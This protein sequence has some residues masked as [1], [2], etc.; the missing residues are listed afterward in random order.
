MKSRRYLAAT[1]ILLLIAA[2]GW[3]A[4]NLHPQREKRAD[5]LV[6][7][8]D[9]ESLTQWQ[10]FSPSK[11]LDKD[12]AD[13]VPLKPSFTPDPAEAIAIPDSLP[14]AAATDD[15]RAFFTYHAVITA[16]STGVA[17][18]AVPHLD[19][20]LTGGSALSDAKAARE[21]FLSQVFDS[22]VM[23]SYL[24]FAMAKVVIQTIQQGNLR[25]G[26]LAWGS[27][28]LGNAALR[29]YDR[30]GE[31][32]YVALYLDYF[33]K[34]MALRDSQLGLADDFHGKVMDA[35]GSA[36]LGR[37]TGDPSI[38]VAHVT[39]FSVL[40]AP[41]TGFAL[42]IRKDP[43]LAAYR[44]QADRIIAYFEQAYPQFDVDRKQPEGT[45]ELWYWRPL[46]NQYEATN[47]L[48]IQG[49][50]LLNMYLATGRPDYADR[51]RA[52]IRIFEKGATIDGQ[53][54]ASWNYNPYFQDGESNSNGR[55]PSEF[56]WKG[57]LTVPFLYQA[58]EAGFAVDPA[59]MA[60]IT[61]NVKDWIV[62]D[63]TFK[64]NV[65]PKDSGPVT[66]REKR[67]DSAGPAASITGFL[68][69][70]AADRDIAERIRVM[71]ATR[72]DIFPEGW[73]LSDKMAR[74][75]A[76]FLTR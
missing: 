61:R 1:A 69:A 55:E 67:V 56:V 14:C 34:L 63:N 51:I 27:G 15:T 21:A 8:P 73:F 4:T 75:Y 7:D 48:H 49:E 60:A 57:G 46:I 25:H 23:Y 2:L 66:E 44:P 50:A 58:V 22:N 71:V 41:A 16:L 32:R 76:Y 47:H 18:A 59:L 20:F 42:R 31:V 72:P 65:N 11:R 28:H 33:D 13:A 9:G 64:R 62:A 53:G 68:A 17:P 40:M 35:W 6:E 29:A 26:Q 3:G 10:L 43:A 24:K 30:T 74:G 5:R 70:A 45:S 38:W 12:Y 36:N 39:H 52:I 19:C 54:F 37:N